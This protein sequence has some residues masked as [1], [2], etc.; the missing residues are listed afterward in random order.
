MYKNKIDHLNSSNSDLRFFVQFIK[1]FNVKKEAKAIA[2][3]YDADAR[4]KLREIGMKLTGV[5]K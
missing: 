1:Y 4:K 5:I 2:Q 3:A